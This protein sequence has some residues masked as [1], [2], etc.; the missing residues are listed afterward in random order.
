MTQAGYATGGEKRP[1]VRGLRGAAW[2]ARYHEGFPL[3]IM[4]MAR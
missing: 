4:P 1:T 3:L 2:A